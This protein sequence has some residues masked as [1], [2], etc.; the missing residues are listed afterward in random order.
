MSVEKYVGRIVRIV[1]MDRHSRISE[2]IIQIKAVRDGQIKAYCMTTGGPR[3][4]HVHN[5]LAYEVVRHYAV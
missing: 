3:V 5:V 1:Y 4:F 2:R